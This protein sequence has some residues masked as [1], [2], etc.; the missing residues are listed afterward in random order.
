MIMDQKMIVKMKIIDQLIIRFM[1]LIQMTKMEDKMMMKINNL[2][3]FNIAGK[4]LKK[5]GKN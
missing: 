3:Y 2:K 4:F 1:T 5:R